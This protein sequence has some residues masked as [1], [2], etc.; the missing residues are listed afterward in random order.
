MKVTEEV[1]ASQ[2]FILGP[3]VEELEKLIAGYCGCEFAV[4]VSSGTDALLI[5]LMA[6]GVGEG[7]LV[8]TSPYTFFATGGSIAR[9]GARP[10][11]VDID[12]EHVQHGPAQS[13]G[14]SVPHEYGREGQTE[15]H[16]AGPSLWP[17]RRYGSRAGPCPHAPSGG[18]RGCGPGDRRG[19]RAAER[20]GEQG[21]NHG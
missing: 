14:G 11:F 3:K 19:I 7:D 13:G 20:L 1:F 9:V 5:S 6:A 15:G 16:H 21:R 12:R 18:H 4:G 2:H 10:V 8:V 17:V